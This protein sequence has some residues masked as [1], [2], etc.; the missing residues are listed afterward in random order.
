MCPLLLCSYDHGRFLWGTHRCCVS[1]VSSQIT[2]PSRPASNLSSKLLD[3]MFS[4]VYCLVN[5]VPALSP[6]VVSFS[7]NHFLGSCLRSNFLPKGLSMKWECPIH[8]SSCPTVIWFPQKTSLNPSKS[9]MRATINFYQILVTVPI[10]TLFHESQM[11][12]Q[13]ASRMWNTE[14]LLS[15]SKNICGSFSLKKHDFFIGRCIS[16]ND[17]LNPWVTGCRMTFVSRVGEQ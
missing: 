9:S 5:S 14:V 1:R 17:S 11:V 2:I 8:I 7:G 3:L 16:Q 15:C 12:L 13:K 10:L 6:C 4:I